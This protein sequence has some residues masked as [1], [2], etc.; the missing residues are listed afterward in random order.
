MEEQRV[1]GV[2]AERHVLED[3]TSSRE[4]ER[5][6]EPYPI[7]D[8]AV[9][10]LGHLP[11]MYRSF[12]DLCARG[13]AAHGRFF[14]FRG[15][16]GATQLMCTDPGVFPILKHPSISTSFYTEGF[17]ALLGNT[18]FAL[19]GE[20]HRRVR[21][22]MSPPFTPQ[23][24][25]RSDVLE[26]VK[27]TVQ[28]RVDG[29]IHAGAFDLV[30]ETRHMALE[31]IFRMI[32]VPVADLAEW[33]KQYNR[34]LLAGLPST[35]RIR[36]P[37]HWYANRA[38]QWIDVRIGD[39]VDGL[40]ASGQTSTLVG[41]IANGRDEDGR[42][43][44]RGSVVANLRLLVFA[45]HET[46]ASSIAWTCL[47][48][49]NAPEL[50]R[51]LGEES[52]S[53]SDVADLATDTS[54]FTFAERLFRE[55]IRLYPTVHSVIRR[56]KDR[57]DLDVGTIQAGTLLNLPL[58]H[59]LRDPARF[60]HPS[61]FDPDRWTERPRPGSL[62]TS[63]FSGGPHFCLGYHVAVSEGTL[64]NLLLGRALHRKKLEL[65]R[66]GGGPVPS[67]VYLPLTHPPRGI[68]LRFAS[69]TG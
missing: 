38:R 55:S 65:R 47:H 44:D 57:I 12:P 66:S 45:G 54:R 58:A 19:D 34:Y 29:W 41:A 43:I 30:R 10:L 60:R 26:I 46:T 5:S 50:Q 51:R 2:D 14:W 42:L 13:Q 16:P 24:V 49:A 9:P 15:G 25:R 28:A 53:A 52:E 31:I 36:G 33:G 32:G 3:G 61:R 22:P 27:S 21:Q 4:V 40:R 37:I 17:S 35:G 69:T 56:V 20:E 67:P 62:E 68:E 11:E 59:Y 23:R 39:M 64:F 1:V 18:L 6:R 48:L 8:G 63:M 7:L